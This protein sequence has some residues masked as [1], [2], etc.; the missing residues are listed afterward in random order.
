MPLGIAG[1][2]GEL[3]EI[4]RGNQFGAENAKVGV[5]S[6]ATTRSVERDVGRPSQC[7]RVQPRLRRI[8]RRTALS[9]QGTRRTGGGHSAAAYICTGTTPVAN[10]HGSS[11]SHPAAAHC[12]ASSNPGRH[13]AG[14]CLGDTASHANTGPAYA[15]ALTNSNTGPAPTGPDRSEGTAVDAGRG[16]HGRRLRSCR[17]VRV[18]QTDA[19]AYPGH[20]ALAHALDAA[21]CGEDAVRIQW[22]KAGLH[23]SRDGQPE[24]VAS[25]LEARTTP[26]EQAD[27]RRARPAVGRKRTPQRPDVSGVA[28]RR[29]ARLT[30]RTPQ[31]APRCPARHRCSVTSAA[32]RSP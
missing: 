2:P 17:M 27:L 32:A 16:R 6:R 21:G 22:L 13:R 20:I 23:A 3:P 5:A 18:K 11:H 1:L 7:E 25:A 4:L 9:G 28:R 19:I 12:D 30:R 31:P 29:S 24:Q 8:A 15:H 26:D 14:H 10:A